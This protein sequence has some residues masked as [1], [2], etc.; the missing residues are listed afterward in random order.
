MRQLM[1]NVKASVQRVVDEFD[2]GHNLSCERYAV[3]HLRHLEG[4]CKR[5]VS[6]GRLPYGEQCTAGGKPGWSYN[7]RTCFSPEQVCGASS[8]FIRH[9][10][11]DNLKLVVI[12]DGQQE[13]RVAQIRD[14]FGAV[15]SGPEVS[16]PTA[17][18]ADMLLALR[19][20]VFIGNP[21]STMSF[22]IRL[23]RQSA[24]VSN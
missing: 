24:L 9:F 7:G 21:A 18:L 5:R 22:N 19:A 14:E 6:L 1:L 15:A 13:S 20:T 23:A 2:A 10:N 4:T 3:V 16:G 17:V 11:P 12:H 8:N